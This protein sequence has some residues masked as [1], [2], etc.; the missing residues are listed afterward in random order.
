MKITEKVTSNA[1]AYSWSLFA[2]TSGTNASPSPM[3]VHVQLL[4]WCK[5]IMNRILYLLAAVLWDVGVALHWAQYK[6][7][8]LDWC[9]NY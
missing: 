4:A 7:I 2:N 8:Y 5:N 1:C 9:E 3:S 6:H